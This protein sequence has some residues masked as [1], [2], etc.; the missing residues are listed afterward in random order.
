M[1]KTKKSNTNKRLINMNFK[2]IIMKNE[3]KNHITQLESQN[4]QIPEF[5]ICGQ[6]LQIS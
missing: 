3:Y 6:I 5:K 2:E 4:L 1:A